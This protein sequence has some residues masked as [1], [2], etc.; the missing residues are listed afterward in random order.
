MVGYTLITFLLYN[1]SLA[2]YFGK[3]LLC[4]FKLLLLQGEM[5]IKRNLTTLL[6]I[7]YKSMLYS[8]GIWNNAIIAD[9]SS[10]NGILAAMGWDA[11]WLF[12]QNLHLKRFFQK[13]IKREMFIKRNL[14]NLLQIFHKSM[15]YSLVILKSVIIADDCSQH[16]RVEM[17]LVFLSHLSPG[18]EFLW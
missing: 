15:I 18:P 1:R 3:I 4:K 2:C 8:L 10:Q 11:V 12:R 7:F 6:Q 16:Q 5:F 13:F 17:Q 9:D 14:I